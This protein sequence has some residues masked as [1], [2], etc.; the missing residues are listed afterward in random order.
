[1]KLLLD[2]NGVQSNGVPE[3]FKHSVRGLPE[4]LLGTFKYFKVLLG[5]LCTVKYFNVLLG[6][7]K[8]F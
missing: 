7:L 4:V 8:Y 2:E 1:M 3:G 5:T 6:T